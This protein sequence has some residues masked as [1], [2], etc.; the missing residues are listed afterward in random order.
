[1]AL[2]HLAS[3]LLVLTGLF[4]A[5]PFAV[6]QN[7]DLKGAWEVVS[8][9]L[10]DSTGTVTEVEIGDPPG[11]KVLSAEHWVFVEQTSDEASPTSGGGGRYTTNDTTYTEYVDYHTAVSFVGETI[12]FRCRV[13]EDRWYQKGIL[14]DGTYLEEVYRRVE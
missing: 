1:M 11:L 14:P 6:G 10:T 7:C 5:A 13:E 12:A 3:R 4:F 8:L 9:T 2:P